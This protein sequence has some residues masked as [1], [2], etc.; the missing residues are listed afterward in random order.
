[1]SGDRGTQ[2]LLD[3][4]LRKRQHCDW[5]GKLA[6]GNFKKRDEVSRESRAGQALLFLESPRVLLLL[7]LVAPKTS[8]RSNLEGQIVFYSCLDQLVTK[9][10]PRTQR[11]TM[12]DH[13]YISPSMKFFAIKRKTAKTKNSSRCLKRFFDTVVILLAIQSK[14]LP[15]RQISQKRDKWACEMLQAG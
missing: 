3:F 6:D 4:G 14:A 8:L 1:M 7:E 2:L 9:T 5:S 10:I 13:H 11:A 15:I 12:A